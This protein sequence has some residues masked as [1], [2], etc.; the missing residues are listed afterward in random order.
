MASIHRSTI[1]ELYKPGALAKLGQ[2]FLAPRGEGQSPRQLIGLQQP[3]GERR[4]NLG[5]KMQLF[6]WVR[7][8]RP[9]DAA[10]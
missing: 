10:R 7:A 1:R 6:A 4:I 2:Y 3:A 8:R 9:A 5:D